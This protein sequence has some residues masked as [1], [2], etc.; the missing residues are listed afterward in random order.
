M[1]NIFNRTFYMHLIIFI[2][3]IKPSHDKATKY[4][5]ATFFFSFSLPL[6]SLKFFKNMEARR[7]DTLTVNIFR[8]DEKALFLMLNNLPFTVY[9][10]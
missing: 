7:C 2:K 4:M 5:F 1:Y 8:N 9:K 3:L 6:I 10:K